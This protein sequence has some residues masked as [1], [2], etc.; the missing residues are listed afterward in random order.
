MEL[1]LK[2]WPLQ[3]STRL[4]FTSLPTSLSTFALS[5][6]PPLGPDFQIMSALSSEGTGTKTAKGHQ[7]SARDS[8]MR[9]KGGKKCHA[10]VVGF[11]GLPTMPGACPRCL[12]LQQHVEEHRSFRESSACPCPDGCG[13]HKNKNLHPQIRTVLLGL[14]SPRSDGY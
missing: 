14:H 8:T 12:G 1:M 7:E 13:G 2:Q 5:P 9:Y 3:K 4:S 10:A 6:S 11:I